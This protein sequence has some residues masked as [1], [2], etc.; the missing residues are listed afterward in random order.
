MKM[1]IPPPLVMVLFGCMMYVLD[2]FLP[3]G[4]FDF[5]GR[6]TMVYV[7]LTLAFFIMVAAFFQFAKAKTTSDPMK[8]SRASALVTKGIY[9][10]SR[11]PMYLAMLLVLVAFGLNLGNAF[12]TLL[13][14]GFVYYL[15]HFQIKHEEEAL[16]TKFGKA[17]RAYCKAVRRWF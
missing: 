9:Q 7:L 8:P 3:V 13:A 14:A 5:F 17:Y 12:N 6:V 2:R 10:F 4:E 11:N 16:N 1:K 15:N